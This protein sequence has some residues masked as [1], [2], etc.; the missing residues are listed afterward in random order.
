MRDG[1]RCGAEGDHHLAA[2]F[3]SDA[4]DGVGEGGVAQVRLD[5]G[6]Q[7]QVVGAAREAGDTELVLRPQ[8]LAVVGLVELDLRSF[9][10]EVVERVGVDRRDDRRDAVLGQRVDC[11]GG[12]LGDVEQATQREHHDRPVQRGQRLERG[13]EHLVAQAGPC[14]SALTTWSM[15]A[16]RQ[17]MSSGS[18]A[19]N[20][21]TRNWLRPS[22][23]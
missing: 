17:A 3:A 12:D 15:H 19:G 9:L 7:H 8:D 5:A 10:G 20:M 14:A 16:V 13:G 1:L 6:E 22:L 23:R 11:I 21:P 18:T 2:Q 4:D